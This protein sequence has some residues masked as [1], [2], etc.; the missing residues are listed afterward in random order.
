VFEFSKVD[1]LVRPVPPLP[2]AKVPVT[3]GVTLP[4]PSKV[5]VDVLAKLVLKVLPVVN[6]Y[7]SSR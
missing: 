3:P 6:R 2:T 1:I 7:F 4:V 5:A